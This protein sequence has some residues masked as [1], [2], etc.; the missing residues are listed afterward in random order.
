MGTEVVTLVTAAT[1]S[2][3]LHFLVSGRNP[4]EHNL[5]HL[6]ELHNEFTCYIMCYAKHSVLRKTDNET[7]RYI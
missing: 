5:S 4:I 1:P 7:Y 2:S 3:F 6:S